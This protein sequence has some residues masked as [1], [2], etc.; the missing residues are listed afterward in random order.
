[1]SL[2]TKEDAQQGVKPNEGKVK[3]GRK[4]TDSRSYPKNFPPW[5]D[6]FINGPSNVP[7]WNNFQS[8][9]RSSEWLDD[10]NTNNAYPYNHR[11]HMYRAFTNWYP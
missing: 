9:P 11:P 7:Y 8:T 1:M 2:S 5:H 6:G 3:S 4:F 10:Y